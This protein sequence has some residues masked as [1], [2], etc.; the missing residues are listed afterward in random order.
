MPDAEALWLYDAKKRWKK[1]K[2]PTAAAGG[3][4]SGDAFSNGKGLIF[5]LYNQT[6]LKKRREDVFRRLVFMTFAY[7]RFARF[8]EYAFA[9][10]TG[11]LFSAKVSDDEHFVGF[12]MREIRHLHNIEDVAV[13]D[14]IGHHKMTLANRLRV[15]R[16]I[17]IAIA[18]AHAEGFVVGDI[19]AR[20]V[21]V[22]AVSGQVALIDCDSFQFSHKGLKFTCDEGTVDFSSADAL[23]RLEKRGGSFAGFQRSSRDDDHALSVL[24]FTTLMR[25]R[26]PYDAR[27]ALG[28]GARREAIKKNAFPYVAN[29]TAQPPNPKDKE[30]YD[31]LPT[32]IRNRFEDA[33]A[34]RKPPKAADWIETFDLMQGSRSFRRRRALAIAAGLGLL[35][36]AIAAA[37]YLSIT[38]TDIG[39]SGTPPTLSLPG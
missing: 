33:F 20:N 23:E 10:P 4:A 39:P 8:E 26:H 35:F 6:W 1:V 34:R 13:S 22:S 37:A 2:K 15:C 5:K 25:G 3:G 31:L 28:V 29:A 11:L 16:D 36:A 38:G 9:W 24:I 17:S 32:A 12:A 7:S 21:A 18:N 19:N 14:T 27:N 30:A